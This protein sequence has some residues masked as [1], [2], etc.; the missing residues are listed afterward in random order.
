MV[1]TKNIINELENRGYKVSEKLVDKNGVTLHG[2]ILDNGETVRPTVYV[3]DFDNEDEAVEAIIK[4]FEKPTPT[5]NVNEIAKPENLRI[6]IANKGNAGTDLTREFLDLEAYVYCNVGEFGDG[7]GSFKVTKTNV[8]MFGLS[9]DELFKVALLNSKSE[10]KTWTMFEM[11]T[12]LMGGCPE[13]LEDDGRMWVLSNK[14]RIRGA[15]VMLDTEAL[16]SVANKVESD[17]LVLP[18]SIHEVIVVPASMGDAREFGEMVREVNRTE[19]E[20]VDRLSDTVYH[21]NRA[22][23]E[24]TIA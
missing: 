19:V 22:T 12:E 4:V 17:L 14:S 9:E 21:F 18:S 7:F 2:L 5:I 11:L 24:L 23:K 1:N 8:K 10:T 15:S 6:A 13:F 16:E 3:D 20:A